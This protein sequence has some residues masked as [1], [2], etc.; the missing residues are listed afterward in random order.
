M[1]RTRLSAAATVLR[2]FSTIPS[3]PAMASAAKM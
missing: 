1:V 3:A 2:V